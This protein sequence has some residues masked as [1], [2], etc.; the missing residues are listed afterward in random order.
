M[1]PRCD[2]KTWR[3]RP[4]ARS[5]TRTLAPRGKK[6]PRAATRAVRGANPASPP[7]RVI[8]RECSEGLR[9]KQPGH[10]R[11]PALV[12]ESNSPPRATPRPMARADR[13]HLRGGVSLVALNV[14][15]AQNTARAEGIVCSSL[16][17]AGVNRRRNNGATHARGPAPLTPARPS[18]LPRQCRA[19]RAVPF[20]RHGAPTA[21][22]VERVL[23]E[24]LRP[25]LNGGGARGSFESTAGRHGPLHSWMNAMR[26]SGCERTNG[27]QSRSLR[28]RSRAELLRL[29]RSAY[30]V[31]LARNDAS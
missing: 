18:P 23:A 13:G 10:R 26:L 8:A 24:G 27:A 6:K 28:P 2:R 19:I 11:L 4:V 22:A 20:R 3:V 29:L 7:G 15:R 30:L 31:A 12:L 1:P 14:A 21:G 9:P 16:D 25:S 17:S 5:W